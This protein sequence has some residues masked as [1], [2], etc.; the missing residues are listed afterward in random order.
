MN[1]QGALK[2]TKSKIDQAELGTK[3]WD[4]E[5]MG[6]H[7]DILKSGVRTFKFQYRTHDGRQGKIKIGRYPTMTVDEARKM[8]RAFRVEVDKGGNPS[9]ARRELAAQPTLADYVSY[10]CDTYGPQNALKPSTIRDARL[11]I[12][13]FA[14]PKYGKCKMTDF[15]QRDIRAI[16]SDAHEKSGKSQ[17][18]RLRAALSKVFNLAIA[19]DV[20][21]RNPVSGVSLYREDVRVS[22]LRPAE[23][24]SLVKACDGYR[25]QEAAN[26]ILL[27]L[28]TGARKNEVLKSTWS[29]FNLENGTWTKPSS[30]TKTKRTH[31][32]SLVPQTLELLRGMYEMRRSE[33]LVPGRSGNAP[34]YD[35]KGPWKNIQEAAGISN[36]RLHDL[37]RTKA[38][39]M[40]STSSDIAT[41]GEMLGHT[42][43]QTTKRYATVFSKAQYEGSERAINAMLGLG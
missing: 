37:R 34:R 18:N 16:V 21:T 5:V 9:K 33:F 41:V 31:V 40:I 29:Q 17:A 19:D 24:L 15:I 3:L 38:S 11:I 25:D 23:V 28:F 20:C 27:L 32:V 10:Y 8:A 36:Y 39:F 6:F 2:L 35:L 26:A 30:H 4:S 7:I 22:Y 1:K 42:Q 14:I 43:V 13:R 12:N